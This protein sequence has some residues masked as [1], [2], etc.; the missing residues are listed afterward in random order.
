MYLKLIFPATSFSFLENHLDGEGMRI[1]AEELRSHGLMC[2]Q[3]L[4]ELGKER[5]AGFFNLFHT[6]L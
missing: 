4:K 1:M 5:G 2:C 3:M 6:F